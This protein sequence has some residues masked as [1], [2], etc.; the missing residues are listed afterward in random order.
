MFQVFFFR[1]NIS[2]L[3]TAVHFDVSRTLTYGPQRVIRARS[4]LGRVF[5]KNIWTMEVDPI[6]LGLPLTDRRVK[7]GPDRWLSSLLVDFG[8][9]LICQW[10]KRLPK[11]CPFGRLWEL[12]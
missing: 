8:A 4:L 7:W 9:F 2:G 5:G 12:S 3:W 11:M 6:L 10:F 1:K